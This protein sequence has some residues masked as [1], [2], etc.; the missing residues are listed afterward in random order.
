MSL[1]KRRTDRGAV[2]DV[3]SGGS[4]ELCFDGDPDPPQEGA[5]LSE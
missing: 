3:D 1:A 5:F 4:K 2:W